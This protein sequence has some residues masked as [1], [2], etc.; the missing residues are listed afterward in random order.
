MRRV[1]DIEWSQI[2]ELSFIAGLG[3]PESS[4]QFSIR[5][6]QYA[7]QC[8]RGYIESLS[9]RSEWFPDVDVPKLRAA[10]QRRLLQVA[11]MPS[12][13]RIPNDPH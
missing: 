13:T 10:A 7:E 6:K 3:K 4:H 9:V 2:Q 5:P 12:P 8:V 11:E 1:H